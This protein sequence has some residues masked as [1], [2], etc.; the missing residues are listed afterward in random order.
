MKKMN[1]LL[2]L[3]SILLLA[4]T[5]SLAPSLRTSAVAGEYDFD[6]AEFENKPFEWG[7]Y[8][9]MSYDHMALNQDGLLY[10]L[11]FLN[12]PNSDINRL[13][14]GIEINGLYTKGIASLNW[15]LYS[16]AE[17]DELGW[18]DS[19]DVYEAAVSLNISPSFTVDIGKKVNKWGKGYAWNPVGFIARPKD[20]SNPEDALEGFVGLNLDMVKSFQGA[21]RTVALTSVVLPVW[22]G[23]NEEFGQTDNVNL[24]AKL[25]LLYRDTDIDLLVYTGNSRSNRFGIDFS[26]NISSNFEVHGEFA[27][28]P[29]LEQK[30]LDPDGVVLARTLSANSWLLGLRYLSST[31]IT[32]II[33]LYHNDAG[34]SQEE[35]EGFLQLVSEATAAF[36]DSFNHDLISK[37]TSLSRIYASPQPGRNYLYARISQKEPFDL[38]YLTPGITLIHN[39]DDSSSTISPE[40]LYNGFT[41]W[42][43]RLRLS[44]H[45]GSSLTENGEKQNSSKADLRLRYFF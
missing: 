37:V 1:C 35:M 5:I 12:Q 28:I 24:A 39:L 8:L 16:E 40:L 27:Y 19:V 17:Q 43:M 31:D 23:V 21:L 38:L 44:S 11:N 36:P 6:L 33:E 9:Q 41:N 3:P 14:A 26:R 42:E 34:A 2:R 25:Y 10:R 7:G 4:M 45:I 18:R 32:S 30:Y 20:P 29:S 13:T 15:L 22:K